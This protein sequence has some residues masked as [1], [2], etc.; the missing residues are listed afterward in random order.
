MATAT[1]APVLLRRPEE[2]IT[3]PEAAEQLGVDAKT[4]R[5]WVRTGKLPATRWGPEGAKIIRIDPADLEGLG[6]RPVKPRTTPRRA[7]R[8]GAS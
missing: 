3:I 8:E 7:R 6:P 4:V 5:N 2:G 1:L